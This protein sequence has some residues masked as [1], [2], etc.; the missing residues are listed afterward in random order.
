MEV[1]QSPVESAGDAADTEREREP[2]TSGNG[3]IDDCIKKL[4][5]FQP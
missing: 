4:I 5:N 3:K 2:S 1:T